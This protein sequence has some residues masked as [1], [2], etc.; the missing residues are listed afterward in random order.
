MPIWLRKFTFNK[1][2]AY[3]EEKTPTDAPIDPNKVLK[4]AVTPPPTYTV[5]SSSATKK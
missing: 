1:L 5:K 4:P 3:Y 2:K